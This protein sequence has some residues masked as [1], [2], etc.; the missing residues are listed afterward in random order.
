MAKI[1][2]NISFNK[3]DEILIDPV[4]LSKAVLAGERFALSKA[5]TLIESESKDDEH[6]AIQ[7]LSN[8]LSHSK[9]SFR[10]GISGAPGSGK[11]TLIEALGLSLINMGKQPAIL[12]IDP[13][14]SRTGG[15][16]LGDKTRMTQLSQSENAFIRPSP[17]G[18]TLGGVA[19]KT[20]ESILL[21]EAAGYD[22]IVI[23]TV[24]VGQSETTVKSMTDIFILLI[25]PG[26]GDEI[27]GIKRGIMELADIIVVNKMDG[28]LENQAKETLKQYQ[29]A[30][31]LFQ[32]ESG[33]ITPLLG[34]SALNSE[35][36]N[37][38]WQH[39]EAFSDHSNDSGFFL[40]NRQDQNISWFEDQIKNEF[41]ERILSDALLSKS[42]KLLKQQV[43]QGQITPIKAARDF[44]Q[45]LKENND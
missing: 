27:Q 1:N 15:S 5:I 24:G 10:I 22:P 17:A 23:E 3:R 21:L 34:M 30:S 25:A 35:G 43:E 18:K 32:N 29:Q 4:E 13:S 6:I 40:K 19:R 9:K 28:K 31:S 44:F 36:I 14:S 20:R 7:L 39:I 2:P 38:L 16:I 12:A 8:I 45:R 41:F 26:A 37:K 42:F 11:S 33:W